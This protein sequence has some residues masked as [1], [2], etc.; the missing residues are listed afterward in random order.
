MIMFWFLVFA[1]LLIG[2]AVAMIARDRGPWLLQSAF[3]VMIIVSTYT[4]SKIGV[5]YDGV[6][7]SVAVGL[8]SATFLM[9]D[10]LGEIWGRKMAFYAVLAGFTGQVIMVVTNMIVLAAPA[11]P[12]WGNQVEFDVVLGATPRLVLASFLAFGAAQI[13]DVIVFD[14]L[15]RLF[16]GRFLFI[17]NNCST[18]LSQIIDT[19]VFFSIGF[20]GLV[21]NI[22]SMI[23]L[24]VIV[25]VIIALIDTP[26]LYFIRWYY[27]KRPVTG[28]NEP[29]LP[30]GLE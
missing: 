9:T 10:T 17:R 19:V 11:A 30:V 28:I 27:S 3:A 2:T 29:I 26:I 21:P 8:Y 15:K 24:T 14:K 1:S 18:F 25:K 23:L 12:F 20:W 7:V 5:A 13:N 16:K 4:A 22:F 6:F